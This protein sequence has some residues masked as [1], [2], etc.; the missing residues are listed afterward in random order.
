MKTLKELYL[1]VFL[2]FFRFAERSW[3]SETNAAKG[4]VGITMVLSAIVTVIAFWISRMIGHNNLPDLSKFGF[5]A[6]WFAV[7]LCNYWVLVA[8]GYGTTFEFEFRQFDKKRQ[9]IILSMG[10][11][12]IVGTVL[13]IVSAAMSHSG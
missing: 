7:Y 1:S 12:V 13:L 9:R 5:F 11:T 10:A 4:A 3:S 2:L 8:K 6:F